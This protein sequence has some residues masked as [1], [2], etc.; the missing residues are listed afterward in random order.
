MLGSDEFDIRGAGNKVRC[1]NQ[2]LKLRKQ[3]MK[4]LMMNYRAFVPH[5]KIY[6][7]ICDLV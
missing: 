6:I 3:I 7:W 4:I 5:L 1:N 2:I